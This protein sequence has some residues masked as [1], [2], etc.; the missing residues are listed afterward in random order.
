[1]TREVGNEDP[2]VLHSREVRASS[3]RIKALVSTVF[4]INT[5][6]ESPILVSRFTRMWLI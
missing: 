6:L 4:H 1:M 5:K 2:V 3:F